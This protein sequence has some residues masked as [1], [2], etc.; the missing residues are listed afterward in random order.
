MNMLNYFKNA[1]LIF[2]ILNNFLIHSD[3]ND[4]DL[5]NIFNYSPKDLGTI[6]GKTGT[7][8]AIVDNLINLIM[9]EKGNLTETG[10]TTKNFIDKELEEA[11]NRKDFKDKS[12]KETIQAAVIG[13]PNGPQKPNSQENVGDCTVYYQKYINDISKP[14][15]V[16][17]HGNGCSFANWQWN[18]TNIKNELKNVLAIEYPSY[19]SNSFSN[20]DEIDKYTTSVAE[21]LDKYINNNNV[22]K[23]VLFSHSFGCNV[24][25]LVYTKLR[26]RISNSNDIELKSVLVFPYYNA[27]DASVCVL[28]NF[29]TISDCKPTKQGKNVFDHI[30]S[31]I[32]KD[33]NKNIF[34]KPF[35]DEMYKRLFEKTMKNSFQNELEF[36]ES[37]SNN[38]LIL[39]RN[40]VELN[41]IILIRDNAGHCDWEYGKDLNTKNLLSDH[42]VSLKDY[43]TD[44]SNFKIKRGD[45]TTNKNIVILYSNKDTMVGNGGLLIAQSF[46]LKDINY[47]KESLDPKNDPKHKNLKT[48][49]MGM[50]YEL[51]K[52]DIKAINELNEIDYFDR[53]AVNDILDT[54]GFCQCYNQMKKFEDRNI[55]ASHMDEIG[56]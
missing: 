3:G 45:E 41:D 11:F 33:F 51:D 32:P 38:S 44:F 2:F 46:V 37:V 43:L 18:D 34:T 10:V 24:N 15:V 13:F 56:R 25:T 36:I 7:Y 47:N 29:Q 1:K 9:D 31:S 23:I 49:Y 26:K 35:V 39:K 17:F 8:K 19:V 27:I 5:K 28:T 12:L 52:E 54:K 42:P 40:G 21:F 53:Q 48:M 14:L 30:F 16:W 4:E 22:K 20:F 55:D 6:M 50:C